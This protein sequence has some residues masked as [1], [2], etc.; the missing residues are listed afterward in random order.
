RLR[1]IARDSD[2]LSQLHSQYWFNRSNS[3][4]LVGR[5][6]SVRRLAFRI[7]DPS[8]RWRRAVHNRQ[9]PRSDVDGSH[10]TSVV[11]CDHSFSYLLGRSVGHY[12][13]VFP[14]STYGPDLRL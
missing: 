2:L 3:A 1:G 6:S 14:V 11:F 13:A 4:R 9:R 7:A 12:G 8:L 5:S 10:P